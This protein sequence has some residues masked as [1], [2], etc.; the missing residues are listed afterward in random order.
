MLSQRN[1][2]RDFDSMDIA[3]TRGAWDFSRAL[4]DVQKI[5][6]L[7]VFASEV[8]RR[9]KDRTLVEVF[10]FTSLVS[11][12]HVFTVFVPLVQCCCRC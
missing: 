1:V 2:I 7:G 11:S 6:R 3:Y 4:V 12:F 9:K 8:F 5:D 10:P